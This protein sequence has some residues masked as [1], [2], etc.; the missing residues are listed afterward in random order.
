VEIS[1]LKAGIQNIALKALWL[2]TEEEMK[3]ALELIE[4]CCR[5]GHMVWSPEEEA[6][7]SPNADA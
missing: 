6:K 4:S 5:H 1:E 3:H 2:G 7:Y